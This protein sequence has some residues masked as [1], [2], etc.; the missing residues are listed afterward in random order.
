MAEVGRLLPVRQTPDR[1][2][3]QLTRNGLDRASISHSIPVL[4]EIIA[5]EIADLSSDTQMR[6][7]RM[8]CLHGLEARITACVAAMLLIASPSWADCSID[9]SHF[10][11]PYSDHAIAARNQFFVSMC[12]D[13]KGELF[14]SSD[15]SLK[16]RLELPSKGVSAH[17]GD[18]YPDSARRTHHE[19]TTTVAFIVEANGNIEDVSIIESSGHHDLDQAAI[20]AFKQLH[21]E[22][23][24]RLDGNAVRVILYKPVQWK[25]TKP[26]AMS[27][28][29]PDGR[30]LYGIASML[31]V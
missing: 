18:Y 1:D 24:A 21:F 8:R 30:T 9:P 16:G 11:L 31:N 17:N 5:C 28:V 22:R 2:G 10:R 4:Y 29:N 20:N 27:L 12:G 23:P 26:Q 14:D 25:L 3:S 13:D 15:P 7:L 6:T 19:G